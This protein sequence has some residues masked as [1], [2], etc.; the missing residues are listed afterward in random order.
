MKSIKEICSKL[1]PL[2]GDFKSQLDVLFSS[3]ERHE[4]DLQKIMAEER[5]LSISIVGVV[6]SGKSSLVNALLFD[7]EDVLP[8]AATPMTAAL[9]YMR[10][11][12]DKNCRAEIE[13]FT[14]KEWNKIEDSAGEYERIYA[15]VAEKL[16]QEDELAARRGDRRRE[17]TR[18]RVIRKS[19]SRLTE[20]CVAAK[21]LVDAAQKNQLDVRQYL[22]PKDEA[23][24]SQV[25][26][27]PTPRELAKKLQEYVGTNGRFTPIVCS[28]TIYL[29]DKRLDGYEIV[30]TPGT[31]DPV[32]F[33]GK[34][35]EQSLGSTD[36]VVLVSAASAFFQNADLEFLSNLLPQ[37]GI[38]NFLLVASQYDRAVG[39]M[40][41]EIDGSLEPQERLIETALAA[42]EKLEVSYRKRISDIARIAIKADGNDERWAKLVAAQPICVSALAYSLS[43]RWKKL[44]NSDKDELTLL[45]NLIQ[46]FT[47][48]DAEMLRQFSKIGQVQEK[49]DD[50][51]GAKKLILDSRVADSEK[52]FREQLSKRLKELCECVKARATT[53]ETNDVATLREKLSKQKKALKAGEAEIL[54]VFDDFIADAKIAFMEV[55]GAMRDAKN[56]YAKLNV[57]T[58]TEN[59]EVTHD[60]GAGFLW[61]RSLFG[62]RYETRI[63]TIRTRY[64]STYDAINQVEAYVNESRKELTSAIMRVTDRNLLRKNLT[65]ALLGMLERFANNETDLTL[66]KA[67]LTS[68][69]GKIDIPDVDFGS[70]DYTRE[71]T[72]AF[73]GGEVKNKDVD[74]LEG[75]Q[76]EAVHRVLFDLEKKVVKK[77]SE[78]EQSITKAGTTFVS[79]LI[80]D[81]SA[82]NERDIKD[83]RDKENVLK[84]MKGHLQLVQQVLAEL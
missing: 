51:K 32:L 66:L 72:D 42:E 11:T 59:K 21:E 30:D 53:L 3:I 56:T 83:L 16:R 14:D 20:E 74:A 76:R 77:H 71:I 68:A 15:E 34:R 40:E 75:L 73:E 58:E 26:S 22:K 43:R 84:R 8:H 63:R 61:H 25:I 49:L 78:V 27:A 69:V 81:L 37:K 60:R 45:N 52:G 67:Q 10:Y 70:L 54:S 18:D 31:N 82:D 80:A 65:T 35:T 48:P 47:F 4:Q 57:R 13:F 28:T 29:N 6:K 9:T 36:V 24:A 7:G 33:R 23:G 39:E 17:V 1:K 41:N 38:K 12:P 19:G 50:I 79:D 46:G 44:S 64:A 62:T 2:Q 55:L 5:D